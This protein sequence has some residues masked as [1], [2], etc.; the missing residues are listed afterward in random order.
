[1]IRFN[2][3]LKLIYKYI[4]ESGVFWAYEMNMNI[5]WKKS[6]KFWKYFRLW[7]IEWREVFITN[8]ELFCMYLI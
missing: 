5:D 3:I 6:E 4:D 2:W 7:E 8:I 1:M